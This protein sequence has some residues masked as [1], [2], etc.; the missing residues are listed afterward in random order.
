ML[1]F[2]PARLNRR[3][4]GEGAWLTDG[5]G[6]EFNHRAIANGRQRRAI[7]DRA[8]TAMVNTP[9][10]ET[11]IELLRP[12]RSH[13]HDDQ[14]LDVGLT[15]RREGEVRPAGRRRADLRLEQPEV[16]AQ[17]VEGLILIP[18]LELVNRV[19]VPVAALRVLPDD[20][21]AG[22]RAPGLGRPLGK[23]LDVAGGVKD[24]RHVREANPP[25]ALEHVGRVNAGR[26]EARFLAV[27]HGGCN[28]GFP[29]QLVG[30]LV[31]AQQVVAAE[32]LTDTVNV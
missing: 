9:S 10:L 22:Q 23:R 3:S 5:S 28:L 15:P 14:L 27:A 2:Q 13:G 16:L 21:E 26:G 4:C 12:Q 11:G 25:L 29:Q 31:G 7:R 1:P 19:H 8:V 32:M 24:V 30:V 18:E 20:F 6:S 17:R